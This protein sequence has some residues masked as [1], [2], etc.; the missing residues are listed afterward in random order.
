MTTLNA[1]P[2]TD[3]EALQAV[4]RP[5]SVM[6]YADLYARYAE[7]MQAAGKTP[8]SVQ[9]LSRALTRAGWTREVV[10]KTR[11]P[12]GHQKFRDTTCRVVPGAALVYEIDD[13]MAVT[14]RYMLDGRDQAF[15]PEESIWTAY[16][17]MAHKHDWDW[18]ERSVQITQ[19]LNRRGFELMPDGGK[20]GPRQYGGRKG[21]MS[22]YV[23]KGMVD[24]I[25]PE[26][27]EVP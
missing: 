1:V 17:E 4:V 11:G 10:R 20:K 3:I 21:I 23:T 7:V 25:A 8:A 26:H 6:P 2:F 15:L 13:R 16:R 22:R 27:P 19:W 14:L 24:R 5:G 18:S 12:R 9:A